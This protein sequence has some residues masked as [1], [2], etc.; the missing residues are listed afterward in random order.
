MKK[1]SKKEEQDILNEALKRYQSAEDA[2]SENI[3]QAL[4][5]VKFRNNDMWDDRDLVERTAQGRPCLT[6]NK[7]EQRISQVTGDQRMNRMGVVVRDMSNAN[8]FGKYDLAQVMSGLIKEIEYRS[9]AKSA[10][11][12]AFDH[13]VGHGFGYAR[14]ITEYADDD[15][16]DMDIRIKRIINP[17]R[18]RLDPNAE[19]A[20]KEDA[21]WGFISS[22]VDKDEYPGSDWTFG[23]GDEFQ[24]WQEEDKVRIAEYFRLVDEDVLLWLVDGETIRVAEPGKDIRD[25]LLK[26]GVNPERERTVIMPCCEWYKMSATKIYEH[27]RFPS[28]FI[29]IIPFYGMELCVDGKIIRRGLIRYAKDPQRIYNYTRTAS[30]EQVALTPKAPYIMEE[31]Q[32]GDHKNLWENANKENYSV[33]PYKHVPGVPPPQRQMPPQPSAGWLQESMLA[34][35]DIDAASGMYKA[36]LGAPSNERSG[37]AINARKMEGDVGTFH[38]H[39]NRAKSLLHIYR[40]LGDMIPRVYDTARLVR[41]RQYDEVK[42]K[43]EDEP[44]KLNE[45]IIDKETGKPVKVYDLTAGKYDYAVDV[46]ASYTTQRQMASESMMELIQYAPQLADRILDIIARNLDWPGADE[47]ADRISNP[48]ITPEQ[49]QQEIQKAVM[50]A[51]ANQKDQIAMYKAETERLKVEGQLDN[52][53]DKIEIELLKLLDATGADELTQAKAVE[54]LREAK[55][56]SMKPNQAA[57]PPN[58][59]PMNPPEP[60]MGQGVDILP[61]NQEDMR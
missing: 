24:Y 46:G 3:E 20:V 37:K 60:M 42:G 13:A 29:P 35:Q 44:I 19:G 18:V 10:Y 56:E 58:P 25:E 2:E 16:F 22:M 33:L 55:M 8:S 34:D 28:R 54:L 38:F 32:L 50:Q 49:M 39:D 23:K 17:F 6:V 5:D 52:D 31:K 12:T 11:D 14:I 4:D 36:S 41:I 48:P 7:L 45:T 1:L 27:K 30:V 21:R 9:D 59:N 26:K 57:M 15:T 40:I 51:L 43:E 61:T 53:E 47:I